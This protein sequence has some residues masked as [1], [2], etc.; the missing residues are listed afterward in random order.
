MIK[1]EVTL[2]IFLEWIYEFFFF[3]LWIRNSW[4]CSKIRFTH[5]GAIFHNNEARW[6]CKI[7]IPTTKSAI[8]WEVVCLWEWVKCYSLDMWKAYIERTIRTTLIWFM[9]IIVWLDLTGKNRKNIR[10]MCTC[11]EWSRSYSYMF[12]FIVLTIGPWHVGLVSGL[13]QLLPSPC[14][15]LL[16]WGFRLCALS[17]WPLVEWSVIDVRLVALRTCTLNFNS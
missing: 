10:I 12:S 11:L 7:N 4:W 3:R 15:R 14:S 17:I 9:Q 5:D 2:L 8:G 13:K 1:F 16:G 6:T